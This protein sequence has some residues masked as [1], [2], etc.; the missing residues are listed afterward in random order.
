MRVHF[1]L[2]SE[3]PS[4]AGLLSHIE[5]LCIE[6]GADEVTGIVPDF[7]R[8]PGPVGRTIED[9][10][11]AT[12]RLE[13][14]ANLFLMHR[15]AD[16]PDPE[17]R[18]REI[19]RAVDRCNLVAQWVAVVPV[20]ETEAWLLLDEGEI[21]RVVGKPHGRNALVL[22]TAQTVENIARPKERLQQI[23]VEAAQVKGRRLEQLRRDF[24]IHCRRLLLSLTLDGPVSRV[25]S[26]RRMRGD[27]RRA[28]DLLRDAELPDDRATI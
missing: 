1:V 25:P 14:G 9:K 8:L 16:S 20:Q 7:R 15:D 6:A 5:D 28:I 10:L 12:M 13:P 19:A 11:R 21:R 27:L 18:Y 3:G 4:D 2:I 24:P 17:P 23:L 26:W 22:P